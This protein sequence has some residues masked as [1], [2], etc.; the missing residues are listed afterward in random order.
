MAQVLVQTF[1]K[2]NVRRYVKLTEP[3][4]REV[5]RA[6]KEVLA[7]DLNERDM[8]VLA[9]IN[10]QYIEGGNDLTKP[11]FDLLRKMFL[12]RDL[13]ELDIAFDDN[14]WRG[15]GSW[16]QEAAAWRTKVLKD[17]ID[18]DQKI[19]NQENGI[20][21]WEGPTQFPPPPVKPHP[22]DDVWIYTIPEQTITVRRKR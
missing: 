15:A 7:S 2:D 4:H 13:G 8:D 22:D 17:L 20:P 5:I 6:F 9:M 14:A 18:A 1:G 10:D 21:P 3:E 19:E 11:Q 12:R 16:G